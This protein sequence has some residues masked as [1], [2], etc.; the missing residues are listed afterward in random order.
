MR[1]N[2]NVRFGSKAD[3]GGRLGNVRFTPKGGHWFSASR[4]DG[5]TP[6][7]MPFAGR[8][9]LAGFLDAARPRVRV[10][11]RVYPIDEVAALVRRKLFPLRLRF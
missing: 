1:R 5:L 11:C 4:W 7:K 10:F 3:I 8:K 9:L 2:S 6:S